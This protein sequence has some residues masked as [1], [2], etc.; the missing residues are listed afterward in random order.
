VTTSEALRTNVYRASGLDTVAISLGV[1]DRLYSKGA[2]AKAI[3]LFLF[4]MKRA[5]S[6]TFYIHT[7]EL[8]SGTN[9]S[10]PTLQEAREELVSIGIL[11]CRETWRQGMWE[12]ELLGDNGG[13]LAVPDTWVVFK[14]QPSEA[15]EAFYADRLGV[16]K[17]AAKNAGGAL[18]FECPFH[19]HPEGKYP[20]QVTIDG[21]FHGMFF[22][23][24]SRRC[25]K[26]GGL[27]KFE[28]MLFKKRHRRR[29]TDRIAGDRVRAFFWGLPSPKEAPSDLTYAS[30]EE[31]SMI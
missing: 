9:M 13:K 28:Q 25:G 5:E 20:L 16:S 4:L 21:E 11:R 26:H 24:D 31:V 6:S 14:E 22:C 8:V 15:I 7:S 17:A 3:K 30:K 19:E 12:W 27:I 18:L 2:S 1:I 10:R 29:L 23:S